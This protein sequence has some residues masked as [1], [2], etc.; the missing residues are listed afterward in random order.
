M[1]PKDGTKNQSL[2]KAL[3]ISLGLVFILALL[4]EPSGQVDPSKKKAIHHCEEMSSQ[5]KFDKALCEKCEKG[6]YKLGDGFSCEP[7]NPHCKDCQTTRD[8]CTSCKD[9]YYFVSDERTCVSCGAN[10]KTCKSTSSC[11]KCKPR[12]FLTNGTES[13]NPSPK[14]PP[15]TGKLSCKA[16]P[17]FCKTCLSS[18]TCEK[19]ISN[20][21]VKKYPNREKCIMNL[22]KRIVTI[23]F[24]LGS[25]CS[26][27]LFLFLCLGSVL[28]TKGKKSSKILVPQMSV[29]KQKFIEMGL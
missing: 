8:L 13:A 5:T 17:K 16:C 2:L 24:S 11:K 23:T 14:D 25:G 1:N 21:H 20:Y 19:C 29:D 9:G 27:L 15:P 3:P 10:C 6:F 7:C 12:Y 28:K 26:I 4:F 18:K 22:Q